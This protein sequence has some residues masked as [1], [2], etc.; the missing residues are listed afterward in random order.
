MKAKLVVDKLFIN[1]ERFIPDEIDDNGTRRMSLD[2]GPVSGSA[3]GPNLNAD[4]PLFV[5]RSTTDRVAGAG[6]GAS[7]RS[8]AGA[9]G[10]GG[11]RGAPRGS[12]VRGR[13]RGRGRGR[14]R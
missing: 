10:R 4:A 2:Q 9:R 5:P 6:V 14:G 1:G 11:S 3:P 13:A 12:T 8:N 7:I